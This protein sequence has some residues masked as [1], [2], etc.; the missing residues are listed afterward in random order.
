MRKFRPPDKPMRQ[1]P[2]IA[3]FLQMSQLRL[4]AQSQAAGEQGFK[5]KTLWP[6]NLF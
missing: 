2:L 3:P 4:K 6:H 5:P 1:V